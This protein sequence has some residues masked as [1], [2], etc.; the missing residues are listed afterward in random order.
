MLRS[1]SLIIHAVASRNKLIRHT[2]TRD[3][4][5]GFPTKIDNLFFLFFF[6]FTLTL[7][8]CYAQQPKRSRGFW[9]SAVVSLAYSKKYTARPDLF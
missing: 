5:Q 1:F 6:I 8:A 4:L 9:T 7:M 2:L 3:W